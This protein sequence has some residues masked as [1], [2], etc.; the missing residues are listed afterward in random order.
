MFKSA[1]GKS[2]FCHPTPK[3][4]SPPAKLSFYGASG[5]VKELTI[6]RGAENP[7]EDVS[8]S[9]QMSIKL[10]HCYCESKLSS[11]DLFEAATSECT[12]K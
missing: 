1:E 2:W 11:Q 6:T 10:H 4:S 12:V 8:N 3:H 7:R 9:L 5:A